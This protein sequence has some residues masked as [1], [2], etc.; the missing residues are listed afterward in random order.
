[1]ARE[2]NVLRRAVNGKKS[3]TNDDDHRPPRRYERRDDRRDGDRHHHD[4]NREKDQDDFLYSDREINFIIG[5]PTAFKGRREQKIEAREINA[6]S[7]TPIQPLRWSETP[8]SFSKRDH[9]THLTES[10][11]YPL[12]VTLVISRVKMARVLVDGGSGLNVL[13][14][15]TLEN[16]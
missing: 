6:I 9:W 3:R 11:A 7:T 10:G 2:C 1:M 13:F 5:G 15:K 14:A 12:V 16:M 4:D 8:V